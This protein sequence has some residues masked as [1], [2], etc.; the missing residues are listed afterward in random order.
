MKSNFFQIII[1]VLL[2]K[3]WCYNSYAQYH[4]E[5]QKASTFTILSAGNLQTNKPVRIQQGSAGNLS[6]IGSSNFS[7]SCTRGGHLKDSVNA[8]L[9]A[10]EDARDCMSSIRTWADEPGINQ[11]SPV[12]FPKITL[13]QYNYVSGSVTIDTDGEFPNYIFGDL[14]DSTETIF[15]RISGSLSIIGS[16]DLISILGKNVV[17]R[18]IYW[19]IDGDLTFDTTIHYAD[20]VGN[21]LVAGNVSIFAEEFSSSNF[22]LIAADSCIKFESSGFEPEIDIVGLK[23][24]MIDYDI[25]NIDQFGLLS[26]DC[27]QNSG[28]VKVY[29][30]V[31]TRKATTNI[32]PGETGVYNYYRE[33]ALHN[34]SQLINWIVRE[35]NR[36]DRISGLGGGSNNSFN[37]NGGIFWVTD[38]LL[39]DTIVLNPESDTTAFYFVGLNDD[40]VP[41]DLQIDSTF[42]LLSGNVRTQNI[43]FLSGTDLIIENG[44]NAHGTFISS[45]K[46]IS[47]QQVFGSF[48]AFSGIEVNHPSSDTL[49]IHKLDHNPK[50]YNGR[51]ACTTLGQNNNHVCNGDFTGINPEIPPNSY[52]TTLVN[53]S[54]VSEFYFEPPHPTIP[55]R[56]WSSPSYWAPLLGQHNPSDHYTELAPVLIPNTTTPNAAHSANTSAERTPPNLPAYGGFFAYDE[57]VYPIATQTEYFVQEINPLNNNRPYFLTFTI[58]LP[59]VCKWSVKNIGM[60]I[61]SNFPAGQ[62]LFRTPNQIPLV[63][64]YFIDGPV[65]NPTAEFTAKGFY[66]PSQL[67][68]ANGNNQRYLLIGHFGSSSDDLLNLG[69]QATNAY[70]F[71]ESVGIHGLPFGTNSTTICSGTPIQLIPG[72][73]YYIPPGEGVTFKWMAGETFVTDSEIQPTV[74]PTTTTTYTLFLQ[75]PG[76]TTDFEAYTYTV[77]VNESPTVTITTSDANYCVTSSTQPTLTAT[78]AGGT[79]GYSYQWKRNGTV[80]GTNSSTLAISNTA[81]Y[82]ITVT[83]SKGCQ[84]TASVTPNVT[85]ATIGDDTSDPIPVTLNYCG[86]YDTRNTACYTNQVTGGN[87]GFEDSKDVVYSVTLGAGDGIY[88]RLCLTDGL[89]SGKL[90]S[91]GNV[92]ILNSSLAVVSNDLFSCSGS[93]Y[94]RVDYLNASAG[95]YYIVVEGK[96]VTDQGFYT[97]EVQRQF[98]GPPEENPCRRAVDDEIAV[99]NLPPDVYPNPALDQFTVHVHGAKAALKLTNAQGMVVLRQ[100][101]RQGDNFVQAGKLPA[102]IYYLEVEQEGK[103]FK[104]PISIIK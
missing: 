55:N 98:Q 82:L 29:G 57:V 80:V 1:F 46:I 62:K 65:P 43:Y 89:G 22:R 36:T 37:S 21:F 39:K 67:A 68:A 25:F 63:V 20:L 70:Y 44:A 32:F 13:A 42:K 47:D 3:L 52:A 58:H 24:N 95:T 61:S 99:N 60:L 19:V 101:L 77:T 34:L 17:A 54:N 8:I 51:P 40:G 49:A 88:A 86:W 97:L 74:S 30:A 79:P 27:I 6:A 90:P 26:G 72:T 9:E 14:S 23:H 85:D 41:I 10:L 103:V 33:Y 56:T 83:D 16:G 53:L 66:V 76:Q 100:N 104:Q 4:P 48:W 69:R 50:T 102:G 7:V 87:T 45:A 38:G 94:F 75:W 12:E 92:K 35:E 11:V 84:G 59:K 71:L 28:K 5:L 93:L 15:V 78:P 91:Q 73:D 96:E 31:G 81:T 64:P 18:N 2:L